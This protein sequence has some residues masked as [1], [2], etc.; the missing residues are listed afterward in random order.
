MSLVIQEME[1]PKEKYATKCP[2]A[3]TPEFIVIHNTMNSAPAKNEIEY[4]QKRPEQ[5]SFH[6][7]VDE[8]EAILGSPLDRN[9]WH[10]GDGGNGKGNRYGIAI[11]ICRSTCEGDDTELFLKAEENGAELAAMILNEKGWDI[12]K[13][14]KHQDFSPYKKYCPHRTL[15]L[16]WDRFLKMVQSKLDVIKKAGANVDVKYPYADN[17]KT[18]TSGKAGDGNVPHEWAKMAFDWAVSRGII[19]GSST[20]GVPEYRLN[21]PITREEMIVMLYRAIVGGG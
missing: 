18:V 5:V 10:A 13:V 21:D 11:E 6:Y 17:A 12:S 3:M 1:M 2:Y 20:N 14:K 8:N 7:A 15:D 19:K 9:C 4:M 16:G